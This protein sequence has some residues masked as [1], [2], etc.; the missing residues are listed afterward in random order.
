MVSSNHALSRR[1]QVGVQIPSRLMMM[2]FALRTP[3]WRSPCCSPSFPPR[4]HAA[5]WTCLLRMASG[6]RSAPTS[7]RCPTGTSGKCTRC[8]AAWPMATLAWPMPPRPGVATR[9]RAPRRFWAEA[10]G[11]G[12]LLS[13]PFLSTHLGSGMSRRARQQ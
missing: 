3:G 8:P 5:T 6:L 4:S 2:S 12:K 13:H 10:A 11:C 7:M 1:K 9:N